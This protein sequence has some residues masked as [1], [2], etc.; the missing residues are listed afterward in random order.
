[1][2]VLVILRLAYISSVEEVIALT[3]RGLGLG[4]F[5]FFSYLPF[6]DEGYMQPVCW[7]MPLLRQLGYLP[8]LRAPSKALLMFAEAY[9]S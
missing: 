5:F 9:G 1:M 2:Y 3:L 4:V 6:G 7:R 8:S